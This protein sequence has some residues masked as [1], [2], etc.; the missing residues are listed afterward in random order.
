MLDGLTLF[1]MGF[2]WGGYESLILPVDPAKWRS[3]TRWTEPGPVLRLHAGL[4][5][6]ADL[7]ADLALGFER[8]RAA[9]A[10]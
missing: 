3:A 9:A 7:I 8:M 1:G 4:E 10:V 6:P 5:D 2:S